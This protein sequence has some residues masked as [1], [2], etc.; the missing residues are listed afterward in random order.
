MEE[1]KVLPEYPSIW[2]DADE[3]FR[4][5]KCA[6]MCGLPLYPHCIEKGLDLTS[7]TTRCSGCNKLVCNA[8]RY[9][10]AYNIF[11]ETCKP[12]D[13]VRDYF[14]RYPRRCGHSFL[15][16]FLK[17]LRLK[18]LGLHVSFPSS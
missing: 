9:K 16:D 13:A 15:A 4:Y 3:D 2:D 5:V 8:C 14:E 18:Q 10:S 17:S 11:C 6:G 1:K 7:S 12:D